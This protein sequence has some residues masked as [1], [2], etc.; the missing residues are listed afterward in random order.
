[1]ILF[2]VLSITVSLGVL[3]LAGVDGASA[4]R[5][6]T[7]AVG[8]LPEGFEANSTQVVCALTGTHGAY[9]ELPRAYT[10]S[11]YGVNSGDSGS[12]FEFEG[13][14]W[15]L[16]GNSGA[17]TRSPWGK[18]NAGSR[19]PKVTSPLDS[20]AALDS[21]SIATSS[22]ATTPPPPVA[23]YDDTEMPPNQRCP[24]LHFIRQSPPK[25]GP[26]SVEPFANPSLSPDPLFPGKAFPVSL[27]SGELPEAGISEGHPA[28]MYV[29]FGT[30]NPA[31]CA[32]LPGVSPRVSPG[33]CPWRSTTLSGGTANALGS[34]TRSVM[35]VYT[36]VG[37]RFR[38]LYD[39][40]VPATRYGPTPPTAAPQD[41]AA[42][43]VNVQMLNGPDGDVY[44]WGTEGGANNDHS[45]VYLARMPAANIATG[46]GLAYWDDTDFVPG[47]ESAATPLFTDSP[48]PCAS[49]LGVQ[50][51]QYLSEW[52]MLYH[53]KETSPPPGH[54]NGIYMRSAPNPW[55]PWSSPTTI[56]NPSP[57]PNTRSGYCYFIYSTQTQSTKHPDG[58]PICPKGSPNSKLADP[59]PK[60][61]GSYYGPY[62]VAN[63]TTGTRAT[64]DTRASTTIY[65]TL[66]T[67]VPYGQLILRSTILGP[68][69]P[70]KPGKPSCHGTSCM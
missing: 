22:E 28:R 13:Q 35:A 47:S 61:L 48:A 68:S 62:F 17:S 9:T 69:I 31:N 54:P 58:S 40:S 70:T 2:V 36:G 41:D 55:G 66:D 59:N 53:C 33:P 20:S 8:Q 24:V 25:H 19:W 29:V 5:V 16:F 44:I 51:N 14:V 21:D 34:R 26:V 10:A 4:R 64:A 50:Y 52:I 27:R 57:D 38:G 42:R 7:G 43:F 3:F 56:F 46:K 37:L 39:L 65:Y 32:A 49:Q 30:D 60:L 6:A 11:L 18:Q 63:W 1:M 67:F 12:S 15:W 45:P 23:P